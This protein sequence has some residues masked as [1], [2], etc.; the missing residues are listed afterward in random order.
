MAVIFKC[1]ACGKES[2]GSSGADA[3]ASGMLAE[4]LVGFGFPAFTENGWATLPQTLG[5]Y[6][7]D[8]CGEECQQALEFKLSSEPADLGMLADY[9]KKF[10]VNSLDSLPERLEK[11]GDP[12]KAE[13][14][15]NAIADVKQILSTEG[16]A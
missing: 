12:T 14:Y 4:T 1:D 10:G 9:A 8:A 13:K 2:L 5:K 16:E 3:Y 6:R 7:L 15:R 11:E